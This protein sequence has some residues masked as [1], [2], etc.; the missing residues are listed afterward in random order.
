M[1]IYPTKMKCWVN[2]L[3]TLT[4]IEKWRLNALLAETSIYWNDNCL[5][6]K[7]IFK[8]SVLTLVYNSVDLIL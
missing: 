8:K 1:R 3:K 6:V 2:N 4:L 7:A 5:I